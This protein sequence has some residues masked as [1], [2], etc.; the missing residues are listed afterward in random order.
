M[1]QEILQHIQQVLLTSPYS[2]FHDGPFSFLVSDMD[3]PYNTRPHY[4]LPAAIP[5]LLSVT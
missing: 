4:L 2:E 1:A 5:V 3:L